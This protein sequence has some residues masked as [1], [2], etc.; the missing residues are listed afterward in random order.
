MLLR[1]IAKQISKDKGITEQEA[2]REVLEVFKKI[3]MFGR[4]FIDIKLKKL[5]AGGYYV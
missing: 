4:K 2:Q 1:D 5:I 3:I